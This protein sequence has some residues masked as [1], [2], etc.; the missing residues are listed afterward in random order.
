MV[1]LKNIKPSKNFVDITPP[2]RAPF[3]LP[4]ITD[5]DY[6]HINPMSSDFNVTPQEIDWA[7]KNG[8]GTLREILYQRALEAVRKQA[9]GGSAVYIG[10][11][12]R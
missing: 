5:Q 8:K 1:D 10:P 11:P 4:P 9:K 6:A 3:Y 7:I 12:P 2:P